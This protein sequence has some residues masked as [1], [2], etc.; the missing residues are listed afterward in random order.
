M[1]I[2]NTDSNRSNEN[3]D[4]IETRIQV[5]QSQIA[6]LLNSEVIKFDN[7]C[8]NALPQEQ[9]IYRIFALERPTETIR[10]GRTKTAVEGLRQRVY[11]NHLMGNQKGNLRKQLVSA[12]V[13][14]NLVAAKQYIRDH[15]AVQFLV[16]DDKDARIWLEHFMLSI[17]RP[18]YC[19]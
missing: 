7:Q 9:G 2:E 16:V 10:A 5:M 11:Q 6:Q 13:C 4:S 3:A 1:E 15:L 8:R 17:L 14:H 12:G 18:K 19:D